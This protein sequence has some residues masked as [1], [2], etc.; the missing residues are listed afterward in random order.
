VVRQEEDTLDETARKA[1]ILYDLFLANAVNPKIMPREESLEYGLM[2]TAE[3]REQI[4]G[5]IRDNKLDASRFTTWLG[6]IFPEVNGGGIRG[7]TDVHA[8]HILDHTEGCVKKFN[9]S[10]ARESVE[11]NSK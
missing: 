11:D 8:K 1:I 3:Q 10:V 2:M 9:E 7:L 6:T 5:L 4:K